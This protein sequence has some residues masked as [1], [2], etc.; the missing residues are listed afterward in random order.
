[1]ADLTDYLKYIRC[2]F[3]VF[4]F[5]EQLKIYQLTE[6]A[7]IY[8]QI[9]KFDD[10]L[11]G[12]W[13]VSVTIVR[14]RLINLTG[15]STRRITNGFLLY[16]PTSLIKEIDCLFEIRGSEKLSTVVVNRLLPILS[17]HESHILI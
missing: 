17:L 7:R 15:V 16:F 5:L 3:N 2:I 9:N 6:V 10:S 8:P 1:M 13:E 4:L 14:T 12:S 11:V